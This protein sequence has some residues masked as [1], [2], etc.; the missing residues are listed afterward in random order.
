MSQ[1]VEY[2]SNFVSSHLQLVSVTYSKVLFALRLHFQLTM[3]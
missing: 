2:F 1:Q 3:F